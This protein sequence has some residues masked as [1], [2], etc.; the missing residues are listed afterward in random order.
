MRA[1]L[2]WLS[3]AMAGSPALAIAG[4]LLWGVL[5]ILVSPCHLASIPLVV[6][7]IGGQGQISTRRACVL[8]TL[9]AVGILTTIA[10]VGLI[11]GLAGRLLGD[12]GPV[13]NY[14]VA[15]IF[16]I[17]G[18][19][20][21]G[22]IELPWLS[23]GAHSHVRRGGTWAALAIGLVF[24][25]ALGPC[26]FAFMAPMLGLVFRVASSNLPYAVS[27]V[28]AYALGHCFLIVVAGTFSGA[29]QNYLQWNERSR[30]AV[31][32]RR[33]CGVLVIAGGLYLLWSAA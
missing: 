17:I 27:L 30:A 18:L 11:T 33:A 14:V 20:L 2:E 4:A 21:V 24:G 26:T 3:G 10:L 1:V 25:L 5:S 6:G 29:V 32:V 22:V 7:F 8:A 9:F 31:M 15:V 23:G 28:L 12:V 13:G 16:F 19:Y